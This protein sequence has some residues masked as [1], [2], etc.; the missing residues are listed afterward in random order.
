MALTSIHIQPAKVG[1][2][3]H[4]RRV[5][6]MDHIKAELTSRNKTWEAPGFRTISSSM[7]DARSIIK[8]KTGRSMQAKAIPFREGVAVITEDTSMKQLRNFCDK[9]Q[10][11]WGIK[12]LAI[13]THLDEGH[14]DKEGNWKGNLHAHIIWQ[15]YSDET[16]KSI[17]HLKSQDF[18]EMQTLLAECLNMERGKSSDKKHLSAIQYKNKAETEKHQELKAENA[19][20]QEQVK[21]SQEQLKE[22][23]ESLRKEGE[24]NVKTFDFLVSTEVVKPNSRQQQGRDNLEKEYSKDMPTTTKGLESHASRLREYLDTVSSALSDFRKRIKQL[25][26]GVPLFQFRK[27][28]LAHEADL[29]GQIRELEYRLDS[30]PI[31]VGAAGPDDYIGRIFE[32]MGLIATDKNRDIEKAISAVREM[33]TSRDIWRKAAL[34]YEPSLKETGLEIINNLH[35]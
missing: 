12:A 17:R 4:N 32:A 30:R 9:C 15:W 34:Q 6:E 19:Q 14:D 24:S 22:Q 2:E 27:G 16:G 18:S 8:E 28:R 10:E 26:K 7:A 33:S 25:A 3:R 29:Q 35:R 23:C 5:R 1:A 31:N 13:Y 20:L 11:K 21:L